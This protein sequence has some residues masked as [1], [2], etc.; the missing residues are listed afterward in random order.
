ML[1]V[2][3]PS[4]LLFTLRAGDKN[5]LVLLPGALIIWP[6]NNNAAHL[7]FGAIF[8]FS[9]RQGVRRGKE[10]SGAKACIG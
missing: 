9:E 5:V 8:P 6:Q 1:I 2:I 7:Y 4:R 10:K 3:P